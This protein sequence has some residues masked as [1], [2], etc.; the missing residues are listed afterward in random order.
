MFLSAL[1]YISTN[2]TYFFFFKKN[3]TFEK[4][5]IKKQKKAKKNI[6]EL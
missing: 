1:I 4:T 2:L 5:Q 3:H 6:K